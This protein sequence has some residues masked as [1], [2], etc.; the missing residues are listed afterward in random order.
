MHRQKLEAR[1]GQEQGSCLATN[2][3]GYGFDGF[4]AH[5]VSALACHMPAPLVA[6]HLH[7]DAQ[8]EPCHGLD[9]HMHQANGGMQM[10]DWHESY[11]IPDFHSTFL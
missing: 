3:D 10:H 7:R 5:R 4:A 11:N 1:K 6:W 9:S 2:N 8:C